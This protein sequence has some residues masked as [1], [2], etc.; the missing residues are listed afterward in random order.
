M[1]GKFNLLSSL[2][3]TTLGVM[4]LVVSAPVLAVDLVGV[5]DLALTSDPQL[6]AA[7]FRRDATGENRKIARSN[8]LP[9]LSAGGRW[10]RGSSETSIAGTKVDDSDSDTSN[11]DLTLFQTIYDHAN[12]ERLDIAKGQIFACR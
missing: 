10:N 6:K 11:Y 7:G 4:A 3:R 5:H 2:R 1:P 9:Q 12:Y 8:L